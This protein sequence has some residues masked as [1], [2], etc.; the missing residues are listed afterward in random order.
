MHVYI[1]IYI[2]HRHIEIHKETKIHIL[3]HRCRDLHIKMDI[4]THAYSVSY[5]YMVTHIQKYIYDVSTN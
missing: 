3:I 4:A 2:L 5:I 1:Y